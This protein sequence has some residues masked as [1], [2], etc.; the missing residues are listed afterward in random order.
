MTDLKIEVDTEANSERNRKALDVAEKAIVL[1]GGGF[2]TAEGVQTSLAGIV[3]AAND[4]GKQLVVVDSIHVP[5]PLKMEEAM[6]AAAITAF[7]GI[8]LWALAK[9]KKDHEM[10]KCDL[11]G[12]NT[13]TSHRGGYCSPDHCRQHRELQRQ[14]H[15]RAKNP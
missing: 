12:C 9:G 4:S 6:A 5:E 7:T 10:T 8:P 1:K 13:L 3:K 2:A 14:T 11:P 15:I